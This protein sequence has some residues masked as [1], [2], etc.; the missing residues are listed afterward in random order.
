MNLGMKLAK[1]AISQLLT[2]L[3]TPAATVESATVQLPEGPVQ[4]CRVRCVILVLGL[5]A[6]RATAI[7]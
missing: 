2:E 1:R 5:L 3:T 6:K 7:R 4:A